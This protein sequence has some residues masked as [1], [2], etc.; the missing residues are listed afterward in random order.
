MEPT[1][2]LSLQELEKQLRDAFIA[3]VYTHGHVAA[4]QVGRGAIRVHGVD[5]WTAV[6]LV[7]QNDATQKLMLG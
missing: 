4:T 1:G 2:S 3:I 5:T 6:A 7:G